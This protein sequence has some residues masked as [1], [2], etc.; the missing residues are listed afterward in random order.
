[1][2]I[3]SGYCNHGRRDNPRQGLYQLV[4]KSAH[5]TVPQAVRDS[6]L[7]TSPCSFV[8]GKAVLAEMR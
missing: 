6:L 2:F 7:S 1:M 3:T 5:Q 4:T 8:M